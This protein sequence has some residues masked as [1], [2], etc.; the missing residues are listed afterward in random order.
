[1]CFVYRVYTF[2]IGYYNVTRG[3]LGGGRWYLYLLMVT[4]GK[5]K[6]EE[7]RGQGWRELPYWE[8][9][10][11]TKTKNNERKNFLYLKI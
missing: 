4:E 11:K 1:M 8:V 3:H 9:I 5:W 10:K 6:H 7:R 2:N